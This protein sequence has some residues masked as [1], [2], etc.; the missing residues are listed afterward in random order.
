D[1]ATRD[2]GALVRVGIGPARK[3]ELV[4]EQ[5][6]APLHE[7]RSL[8]EQPVIEGDADA[9]QLLEQLALAMSRE[10]A[11]MGL[12]RNFGSKNRQPVDPAVRGHQRD[13]FAIGGNQ[14]LG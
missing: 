2:L 13:R 14:I 12:L 6:A 4:L 7:T 10:L 1:K 8:A 11:A 5:G 3:A 9:V